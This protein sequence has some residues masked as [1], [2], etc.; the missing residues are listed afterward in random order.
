[1]IGLQRSGEIALRLKHVADLVVGDGKIALPSGVAG[2]GLGQALGNG[3]AV[4][5]GFQCGGEIALRH[6]H[7]ADPFIGDGNIALPTNIAGIATG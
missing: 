2:I 1:L 6:Q 5:V 3:E 7:I 4:P